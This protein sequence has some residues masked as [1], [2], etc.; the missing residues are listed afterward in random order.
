MAVGIIIIGDE[1]LS[2]RRQDKHL[3]KIIELLTERGMQLGWAE[4]VGDDPARITATLRRTF[5]SEDIVFVTGGIGATPDDHTRQCAAAALNVPLVLTPEAEAL[6]MERIAD[7]SPDGR[8]DMS[9][10]DNRHRLK[11]GEFPVGA[12]ILPNP[13][14]KI[15]GFSIDHH[16]FMPGFPVMAW[17]MM[18]WV[19]DTYYA[20]LHHLT[21]HAERS[22]LVFGL[23]ESTLTPLMETIEAEYAGVKVFSLPSVGDAQR[24]GVYARRHIDLGV[25][26]DS[27]L[28]GAAFERLLA[29]V[30]ALGGEIIHPADALAVPEGTARAAK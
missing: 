30:S 17:P 7:T 24:G 5:A 20:D 15:P 18:A 10:P 21:Q 27:A 11:M 8:A 22:V 4:Y 3:P 23:A 25:K 14:N 6:I 9:Q 26:G 16:H 29:G 28:V 12:R 1:I 2:G 19:L 13:Y